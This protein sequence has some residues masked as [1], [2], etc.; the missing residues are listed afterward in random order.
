M[1]LFPA[2]LSLCGRRPDFFRTSGRQG[3]TLRYPSPADFRQVRRSE[4]H[5]NATTRS[6][7]R[8]VVE[9]WLT[10]QSA[11]DAIA[12]KSAGLCRALR[13][14]AHLPAHR[15]AMGVTAHTPS[16]QESEPRAT[17]PDLAAYRTTQSSPGRYGTLNIWWCYP[18]C[19]LLLRCDAQPA[20]DRNL[21]ACH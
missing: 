2:Q 10:L 11:T 13:R 17:I 9:C 4:S 15:Q 1:R 20:T 16:L 18:P 3:Y 5:R 6:L 7:R 19:I 21:P 8:P 12:Q 14:K